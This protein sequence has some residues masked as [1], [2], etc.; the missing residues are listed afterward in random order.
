MKKTSLLIAL[1]VSMG[2]AASMTNKVVLSG[3]GTRNYTC[4][5]ET[6]GIYAPSFKIENKSGQTISG[7]KIYAYFS[8]EDVNAVPELINVDSDA[9]NAFIQSMAV[10]NP[11]NSR[12]Y[13]VEATIEKTLKNGESL[14]LKRYFTV[15]TYSK[16]KV[17]G[18]W[19]GFY[20]DLDY[21][22]IVVTTKS[23]QVLHSRHPDFK[24][25]V[26]VLGTGQNCPAHYNDLFF[27]LDTEDNNDSSGYESGDENP[28][29][30]Y[31]THG[32]VLMTF[33]ALDFNEFK[34]VSYDYIV[35]RMD[36]NCPDGTK[37]FRRHHDTEDDNNKN[38]SHG[39]LW[40]S[41]IGN[42]ADLEFCLVPAASNSQGIYPFDYNLGLFANLT[43][44][45]TTQIG[46]TNFYV[47]DEDSKN[48]NGWDWYG[49]KDSTAI[50][51]RVNRIIYGKKN[52]NYYVVRKLS[53]LLK[54]AEIVNADIPAIDEKLVSASKP[55]AAVM[56]GFDH[57][58]VSFEIGSAG[59]AKITIANLNG[60]VVARISKENLQPGFHRVEWHSGIIPNGRYV[61]TIEHNGVI[62]GTNVILK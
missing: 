15:R 42:N 50:K 38:T 32:K 27:F 57:A 25:R 16:A 44:Q 2:F 13:R 23:G 29:G 24:S 21:R 31:H 49:Q 33:C 20:N 61:V 1:A 37:P 5:S 7:F 14:P 48:K 56:K 39:Q 4:N 28:I 3:S 46:T 41:V 9:K 26:G 52:T 58:A 12:V 18:C 59:N 47:D 45:Y 60:A 43:N 19:S 11:S 10:M 55:G 40:P 30:I 35:L 22:D 51:T 17:R 62:S 53:P 8:N 54:S 34:R 6:S 36:K